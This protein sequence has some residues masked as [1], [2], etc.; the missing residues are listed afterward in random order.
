MIFLFL[1]IIALSNAWWI[2]RDTCSDVD[3]RRYII[4]AMER[5]ADMIRQSNEEL[6]KLRNG[7]GHPETKKL[8]EYIF[9]HGFLE[10]SA[11]RF[12]ERLAGSTA[13]LSQSA[14]KDDVLIYCNTHRWSKVVKDGVVR[15]KDNDNDFYINDDLTTFC[16]NVRGIRAITTFHPDGRLSLITVCVQGQLTTQDFQIGTLFNN[17]PVSW[18]QG[19]GSR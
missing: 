16:D 13:A 4:D 2:G 1:F 10:E 8:S 18:N 5:A 9:G 12:Y 6:K 15:T 14:G 11:A 19:S 17:K 7:Q 3:D